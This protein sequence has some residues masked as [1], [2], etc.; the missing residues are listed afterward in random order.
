MQFPK[1][2][3][4]ILCIYTRE[5][6]EGWTLRQGKSVATPLIKLIKKILY[7]SVSRI[8]P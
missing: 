1:G 2:V 4:S 3:L 6:N 5:L 7:L 8:Y